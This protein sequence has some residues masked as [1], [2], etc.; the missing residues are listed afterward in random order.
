MD[1]KNGLVK[2]FISQKGKSVNGYTNAIYTGFT[3]NSMVNNVMDLI[4]NHPNLS[5]VWQIASNSISK[6]DLL[7]IINEKMSLDIEI[8]KDENFK[9]D[10][11]LNGKSFAEKTEFIAPSWNA[12][13]KKLTEEKNHETI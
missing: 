2:W 9:C 4:K 7:N 10:R 5:G 12:M 13:I 8:K 3:T 1:T 11:S 6:Y